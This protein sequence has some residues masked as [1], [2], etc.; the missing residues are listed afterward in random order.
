MTIPQRTFIFFLRRE[1]HEVPSS[2]SV[3]SAQSLVV[4]LFFYLEK[5]YFS[6][7]L[8]SWSSFFKME[9]STQMVKLPFWVMPHP[10][11]PGT[12]LSGA[13]G[14]MQSW[15][16]DFEE[17]HPEDRATTK[18]LIKQIQCLVPGTIPG[19]SKPAGDTTPPSTVLPAS[20][21]SPIKLLQTERL[22]SAEVRASSTRSW[23]VRADSL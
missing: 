2:E 7:S 23:T 17:S 10:R 22:L 3:F 12:T 1:H 14:R 11:S 5:L 13:V 20:S 8:S 16:K 6:I 9:Q 18:D 15:L 19:P 4:S 21:T